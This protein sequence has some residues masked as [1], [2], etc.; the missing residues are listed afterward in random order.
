MS[1]CMKTALVTG[2]SGAI[3][4]A[5]CTELAKRGY[6]IVINY[7][8]NKES[9][10]L[11][12]NK[13]QQEYCVNTLLCKADVS[14]R[15]QVDSMISECEKKFG[16]VDIL[17]NNAGISQIKLFTDVTPD[18][19]H[20]MINT[21][22][23]GAFNV[24]QAVLP[25]MIRNHSG[26]VVNIS[27]MWGQ[28]GASCEVSYSTAK[29]GL[30]GFTKALAKELAPSNITVNCVAPGV[31]R[32]QMLNEVDADIIEALKEETPVG[33]LGEPQD[34]ANAVAFLTDE[35]SSFI[36]GQILGVNGGFVI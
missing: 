9:A 8:K 34:I 13:L 25:Y 36:T 16:G 6:N 35:K 33:R 26:V 11:L 29:A 21:N 23:F 20:N 18:E 14:D 1:D 15:Y 4:S 12:Q 2:A 7:N 27:S 28:T 30:I 19:W 5:V 17:V 10:L 31:I 3:G 22:L 24:T 32:T